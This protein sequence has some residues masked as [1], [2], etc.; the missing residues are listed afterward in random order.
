[1]LI[2]RDSAVW[3]V[4][5]VAGV[6]TAILAHIDRFSFISG[7]MEE[8]L[9]FVGLI[10][11]VLSAKMATSPLMGEQSVAIGTAQAKIVDGKRDLAKAVQVSGLESND[12]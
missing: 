5:M 7:T 11:A 10:L 8:V 12:E 1:M 4:G 3:W 9:S 2:S 6:I